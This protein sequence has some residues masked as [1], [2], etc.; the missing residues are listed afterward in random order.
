VADHPDGT[1]TYNKQISMPGRSSGERPIRVRSPECERSQQP[2]P[3]NYGQPEPA[4]YGSRTVFAAEQSVGNGEGYFLDSAVQ[5]NSKVIG[6]AASLSTG[7]GIR[8]RWPSADG[9]KF[10]CPA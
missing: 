6:I 10:A 8:N 9:A 7:T 5:F 2:V 3:Y 4:A 1:G